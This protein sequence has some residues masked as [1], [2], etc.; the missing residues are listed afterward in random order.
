M[1]IYSVLDE[2]SWVLGAGIQKIFNK[3]NKNVSTRLQFKKT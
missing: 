1:V 2:V 3:T